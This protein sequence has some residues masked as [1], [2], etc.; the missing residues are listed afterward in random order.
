[1]RPIAPARP[2]AAAQSSD[3]CDGAL[4]PTASA[5][6]IWAAIPVTRENGATLKTLAWRAERPPLKSPPPHDAAAAS[7][8]AAT[9]RFPSLIVAIS[10][11][12]AKPGTLSWVGTPCWCFLHPRMDVQESLQNKP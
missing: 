5:N 1:M 7:P 8:K 3:A 9:A 4:S 2:A 6:E 11:A 10:S 12:R